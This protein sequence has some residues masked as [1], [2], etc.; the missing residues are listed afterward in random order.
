MKTKTR[1]ILTVCLALAL[2]ASAVLGTIAYMTAQ[3]SKANTFTVGSFNKPV[4]PDKPTGGKLD[5]YILEKKW[6][7]VTEHKLIPGSS[8]EKDPKV[9]IG[10]G[11]EEAWVYVYVDNKVLKDTV[12][13]KYVTF[14]L[15]D[16]WEAVTGTEP[17]TSGSKEYAGGLFKYSTKLTATA[18]ADAWTGTIFDKVNVSAKADV[19]DF[20]TANS[21]EPTMTVHA[22][23]HQANDGNSAID[24]TTIENAAKAW[25]A[26]L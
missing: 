8:V 2:V 1:S 6:D 21:A 22:F 5:S 26:S 14:T 15:N 17:I 11:S 24:T 10:A 16:G 4:D 3:D 23:I 12:T 9:G 20:N 18:D 13:D 7:A 25:A 19:D